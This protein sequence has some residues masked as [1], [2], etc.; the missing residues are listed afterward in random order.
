[1]KKNVVS[2]DGA[3][4]GEIFLKKV[5]KLPKGLKKAKVVEGKFLVGSSETGHHHTT[6]ADATT[7]YDTDDPMVSYLEVKKETKLV[8]ERSFYTH[9]PMTFLPGVYKIQRQREFSLE[10]WKRVQ[11]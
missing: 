8:H 9:Q 5:D 3:R 1:M 6:D 10:G 7:M 4:Q 11:D 2:E